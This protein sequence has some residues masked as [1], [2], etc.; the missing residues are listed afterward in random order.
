MPSILSIPIIIGAAVLPALILIYYIYR[1]DTAKEPVP[2]LIAGFGFGVLSALVA[3][4]FDGVIMGTGLPIPLR[5][6][7]PTSPLSTP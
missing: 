5:F 4:F 7:A 1:R 6:S 2:Q 3:I